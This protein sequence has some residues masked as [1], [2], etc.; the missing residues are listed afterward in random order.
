MRFEFLQTNTFLSDIEI[1]DIGN[2]YIKAFN[3]LGS[4]YILIIDTLMGQSRILIYGPISTSMLILPAKVGLSYEKIEFNER[5][6]R[7][8]ISRFLN[9][10]MISQ[11]FSCTKEEV[12]EDCKDIFYYIKQPNF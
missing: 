9:S 1:E 2:C 11:A 6:L 8:V 3:D 5:K 4:E 7:T 10:N 12:L